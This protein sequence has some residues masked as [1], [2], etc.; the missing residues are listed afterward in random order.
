[1]LWV[2]L[3]LL[4]LV[5]AMVA[6]CGKGVSTSGSP[7]ASS[8]EAPAQN[9]SAA[10]ANAHWPSQWPSDVPRFTYG[11]ITSN[12]GD[13]AVE[14]KNVTP[15]AFNKYQSDLKKAGWTMKLAVQSANGAFTIIATKGQRS[16]ATTQVTSTPGNPELSGS[17]VYTPA[18][19]Q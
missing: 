6:G 19:G 10:Q 17:V 3:A 5:S 14:F 18:A 7:A 4:I 15:V 1:M 9:Q 16:V 11:T 2:W 8:P 13:S 12:I